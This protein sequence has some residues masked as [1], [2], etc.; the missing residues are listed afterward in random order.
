MTEYRFEHG[1]IV[2]GRVVFNVRN[3][4]Q[5]WHRLSLIPLPAD[6][7]PL[8]EQLRGDTRQVVFTKA[9]IP[10][11]PPAGT[12]TFA[13]DLSPGRYAMVCLTVGPDGKSHAREGMATEFRIAG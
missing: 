3:E 10:D 5:Q 11:T 6:F 9:T 2:P 12:G 8:L 4:G 13:V 1:Q 7:P